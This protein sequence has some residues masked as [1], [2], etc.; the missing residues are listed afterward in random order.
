MLQN[1]SFNLCTLYST[2]NITLLMAMSPLSPNGR[3]FNAIVQEN[4]VVWY[5]GPLTKH[6]LQDFTEGQS[7]AQFN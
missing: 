4:L 3:K 5:K 2:M 6:F 1:F 7:I